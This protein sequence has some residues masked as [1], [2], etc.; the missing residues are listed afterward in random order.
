MLG[1]SDIRKNVS[2]L[3]PDSDP[4]HQ[5]LH[6]LVEYRLPKPYA[7][8]DAEQ[9]LRSLTPAMTNGAPS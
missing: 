4:A 6:Q 8:K 3:I 7:E 5:A 2:G 9:L 1:P